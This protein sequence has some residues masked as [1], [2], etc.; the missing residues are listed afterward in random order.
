MGWVLTNRVYMAIPDEVAQYA[1]G[2]RI[3]SYF[4]LGSIHDEE[5]DADKKFWLWTTI[6]SGRQPYDFDG[7]RVFTWNPKRHRY[8]TAYIQRRIEGF[9]PVLVEK[10]DGQMTFSI[11]LAQEDGTRIRKQFVLV[12]RLIRSAGEVPCQVGDELRAGDAPPPG[13][14]GKSSDDQSDEKSLSNRLRQKAGEM[15][16]RVLGR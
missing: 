12:D 4:V 3:V 15:K 6:G 13:E 10:R 9:L 5:L 8:E 14:N 1:E 2:H 7:F 16:S 11:C